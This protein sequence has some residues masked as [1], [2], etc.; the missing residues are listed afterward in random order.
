MGSLPSGRLC[1]EITDPTQYRWNDQNLV[2][3]WYDRKVKCAEDYLS[4]AIV[5][6]TGAA[7]LAKYRRAEAEEKARIQA[8]Q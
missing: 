2:G 6:L 1:I 7:A 4:E 3:R 8:E 5:A